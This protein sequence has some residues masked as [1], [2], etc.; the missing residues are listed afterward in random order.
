MYDPL[1]HAEF[2]AAV[3]R[4]D[5]VKIVRVK[6]TLVAGHFADKKLKP[7]SW[8]VGVE[9]DGRVSLITSRRGLRREWTELDH[10]DD[11][12]RKHGVRA[13]CAINELD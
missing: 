12:L 2:L 6:R 13:W 9:R 5:P 3:A 1:P 4:G 10:A 11:F 7:F 8:A